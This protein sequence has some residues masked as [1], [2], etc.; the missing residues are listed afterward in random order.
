[1]DVLEYWTPAVDWGQFHQGPLSDRMW[2]AFKNLVLLCH[3]AEYLRQRSVELD[4]EDALTYALST[5]IAGTSDALAK[6]GNHRNKVI[7]L[8]SV[9]MPQYLAAL[10]GTQ[11]FMNETVEKFDKEAGPLWGTV[12]MHSARSTIRDNAH[13]YA[14]T[15]FTFRNAK[16]QV[17][18]PV[19][20]EDLDKIANELL[21]FQKAVFDSAGTLHNGIS[22]ERDRVAKRISAL[23]AKI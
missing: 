1:M 22:A 8:G 11:Q 13:R 14:Y 20:D 12:E 15:L 2:S 10:E 9:V 21:G 16:L 19:T 17:N 23:E 6:L 7:G 3:A 4:N 18:A 5:S